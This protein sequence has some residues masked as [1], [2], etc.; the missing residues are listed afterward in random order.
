MVSATAVNSYLGKLRS[1]LHKFPVVKKYL[2]IIED[3][4]KINGEFFVVG[5]FLP[6]LRLKQT[7]KGRSKINCSLRIQ[8]DDK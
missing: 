7:L 3:K 4:T 2:D 1:E 5:F 6:L 8:H